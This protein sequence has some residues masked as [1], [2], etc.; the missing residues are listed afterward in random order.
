MSG[1]LPFTDN[2]NAFETGIGNW[3][4]VGIVACGKQREGSRTNLK[5]FRV[6]ETFIGRVRFRDAGGRGWGGFA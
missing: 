3:L 1:S 2:G 4:K 5:I 6:A